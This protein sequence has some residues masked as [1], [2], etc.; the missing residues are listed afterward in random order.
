MENGVGKFFSFNIIRICTIWMFWPCVNITFIFYS[1]MFLFFVIVFILLFLSRLYSTHESRFK[2]YK[3]Y[4]KSDYKNSPCHPYSQLPV[5]F[6]YFS[7]IFY[8]ISTKEINAHLGSAIF[9]CNTKFSF[10]YTLFCILI[11]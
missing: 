1:I 2:K 7:E 6:P 11:F 8:E 9:L 3:K 10:L 5:S 4:K